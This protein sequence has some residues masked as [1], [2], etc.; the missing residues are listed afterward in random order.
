L[1]VKQREALYLREKEA[2]EGKMEGL[3]KLCL[4]LADEKKALE[5]LGK[6]RDRE[7]VCPS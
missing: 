2:L 1:E 3:E 5:L 4:R 6:A 7:Y